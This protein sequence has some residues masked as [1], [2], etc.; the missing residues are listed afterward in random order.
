MLAGCGEQAANVQITEMTT[1]DKVNPL[2]IDKAP[3]FSWKMQ[4][5][6]E[7]Q[8]QNA[9]QIVVSDTR[10][11]LQKKEYVW[12]S[13]KVISDQSVAISYEGTQLEPEN[14]Y[15]WQVRVWDKD[16]KE[17][18]SETAV[19]EMGKMSN[20]W[21]ETQWI[22]AP[23][24]MQENLEIKM[25]ETESEC[26]SE[27]SY[28]FKMEA[29]QTGF[30]WGAEGGQFGKY[31]KWCFDAAG[32][33]T[34]L[35]ISY[36]DQEDVIEEVGVFL[37]QGAADFLEQ[38]HKVHIY[39]EENKASTYVDDVLVSRD[40]LLENTDM[41]KIGFWVTR[42]EHKAWYD[43]ICIKNQ[44][45][46][47]LCRED[48]EEAENI[49]F[50]YYIKVEGGWGRAD[51]GFLITPGGEQPA[52]MFRKEFETIEGKEIESARVYASALGIFDAY[53]NGNDINE[54]YGAPG[55][56]VYSKEVYYRTYDVIEEIKSGENVIG[57]ILGHGR[58]DRAKGKW[59]DRPGLCAQVV[60]HYKDGTKQVIGTDESWSVC[61]D[62]PIRSD[63]IFDGELYDARYEQTGWS[64]ADFDE[65]ENGLWQKAEYLP[66]KEKLVKKAAPDNGVKCIQMVSPISVT[67]PVPGVY[68]YDFGKNINGVCRLKLSGKAG[69]TVVM[70]HGEFL[71]QENLQRKDDEI[72]TI[73]TR[74]LYTADNTDYYIF[75]E[76]GTITY[77]PT[78]TY[79]GFRYLQITGVETVPEIQDIEG[80]V[81]A[82]E[83]ERTGYF[84][85]SDENMN[86]LYEA[87]YLSQLN[88]YV[89]IPTDC[90]QRDERLGWAGDG[91]VYAYTGSLNANISNFMYKYIDALR[92]S[93]N[94]NGVYPHIAP[95]SDSTDAANGWSD[96]GIILV[97][98]MY[99]QYGNPQVIEENLEAMCRYI[100]H[101]VET[102]EGFIRLQKNYNDHNALSYMDDACCNTA[103][104]TYVAGL[105]AK[106]CAVVEEKE[107]AAK[108]TDIYEKYL[109]TWRKNFL[110][111]DGSIGQWMQSEY[112]LALA[113]GLYP[114]ELEESGGEKLNISVEA[115]DYHISTG[116]ITTPHIL[117]LLCK[118][119]YV[120]S[121]YKMIQQTGYS[122]WNYMLEQGASTL[123]E[124][125]HTIMENE[126][127]TI[128]INGSLNHVA[129]GAVGQWFYTDVLGIRRDENNPGYKH[130]YLEPQ[131]GGGLTYAKGSYN[132]IYGKIE[133]AW[134]V[135]EDEMRFRFVIPANT[136]ATVTL[137][138]EEYAAME[139]E[140]GVYEFRIS[141][142]K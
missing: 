77:T 96:A 53:I 83:N 21:E 59:G 93:Q 112:A 6:K 119:S 29:T 26:V 120:E 10:D 2:G 80:V 66:G 51:A 141:T 34:E 82:T 62:G 115:S 102:S 60:I 125:W 133:S 46:E 35:T 28:E 95:F 99:Q 91:Q 52:P 71:N 41:G 12:D 79:R 94:S 97:W 126:D 128:T 42:G 131:I 90:A 140:A 17:T 110:N 15:F 63:D 7:G 114:K 48:F 129:L 32:G 135:T 106:M 108:Y 73:W 116:Y 27:I 61:M 31:Y 5:S 25:T 121:A 33:Q 43:N 40:V 101:L 23:D 22:A 72:G 67:E 122:S 109:A 37:E 8:K 88:N 85:C 107:L 58:Y 138:S 68:V 38:E 30:V 56:S 130:F 69:D 92:V 76:D 136:S 132:S 84:E 39:I 3:Y 55:Q 98:E 1:N 54:F 134:E 47:I 44:N 74:N 13:G 123:T 100:D 103:Q 104:C 89:D 49:F 50:P 14:D 118:Y 57:F 9:Y 70:R 16:E 20:D 64:Q 87:I 19:F 24:L 75:K 11:A 81:L 139:L 18:I 78:L 36:M 45:G 65:K 4:D 142:E 105:L 124:G 117:S 113:Y 137:P 127:G 86:R 111:E